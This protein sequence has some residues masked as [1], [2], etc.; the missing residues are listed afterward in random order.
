MEEVCKKPQ[1]LVDGATTDKDE[2]PAGGGASAVPKSHHDLGTARA[3]TT[4]AFS[5]RCLSPMLEYAFEL[6]RG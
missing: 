5:A 1:P 2:M 4:F 3:V 6:G